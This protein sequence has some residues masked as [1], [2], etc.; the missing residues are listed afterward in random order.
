MLYKIL[1]T[2]VLAA[3]TARVL[4]APVFFLGSMTP[5][6]GR[7]ASHPPITDPLLYS[8]S[9]HIMTSS[10]GIN[11]IGYRENLRKIPVRGKIRNSVRHR[12]DMLLPTLIVMTMMWMKTLTNNDRSNGNH[13]LND[14]T[15]TKRKYTVFLKKEYYYF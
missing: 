14:N 11:D 9:I 6:T 10:G 1:I 13:H 3:L 12:V 8:I 2:S 4:R 15:V 5:K 7:F